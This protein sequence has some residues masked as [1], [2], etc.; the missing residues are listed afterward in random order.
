M[1]A[2]KTIPVE[3]IKE[4]VNHFL[5]HSKDED[6]DARLATANLLYSILMETGNY[7]GFTYLPSEI[8]GEWEPWA[9]GTTWLRVG[10]DDSR[11]RYH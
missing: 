7:H 5:A 3:R 4:Q 8:A 1:A 9:E 6:K 2:R 10:Y 11:R